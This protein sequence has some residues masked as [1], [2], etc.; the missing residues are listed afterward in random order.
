M[1]QA[2]TAVREMV[3]RFLSKVMSAGVSVTERRETE[4]QFAARRYAKLMT[5]ISLWNVRFL[6]AV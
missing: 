1:V 4:V 3:K 2:I 5:V 6:R